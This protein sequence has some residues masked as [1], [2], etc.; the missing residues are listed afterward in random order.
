MRL[1]SLAR[2]VGWRG[3][4]LSLDIVPLFETI[5]DLHASESIMEKLYDI[6][7]Y[8]EHLETRDHAQTVMLGFSD[9]TKDGGYVSS[10]WSILEA[11]KRLTRSAHKRGYRLAFFDGRGG[12]PA[13][14]GGNA[15]LFYA[16]QGKE[17]ASEEIQLTIQGQTISSN[18]GSLDSARFNL[19]QLLSAGV[20]NEVFDIPGSSIS[21]PQSEIIE[22]LSQ[23]SLEYYLKLKKTPEFLP[24]LQRFGPMNYYG[25][26][27]IGSRP[28]TRGGKKI[29]DLK[30]LRAIP[31]VSTC[32]QMKQNIPGYYGLG[33]ALSKQIAAGKLEE[34]QELYRNCLFFRAL[35]D[36][37]TQSLSK[38]SFA[39]TSFIE[40]DKQFGELW[41]NIRDEFQRCVKCILQITGQKK[42]MDEHPVTQKSIAIREEIMLPLA[43]IQQY[44]LSRLRESEDSSELEIYEKMVIR[45]MYGIVNASRNS[46]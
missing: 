36:N 4:P 16:S 9:G 11:K 31:F 26:T 44:A 22:Q 42:L 37:S 45:S 7:E 27:N 41:K 25:K 34:L 19:E 24:Y 35:L 1:F 28:T 43:V 32:S 2:L 46:A 5:D 29:N 12:P 3:E 6:P 8:R 40:A 15:H 38:S 21:S 17:I 20:G 13:R 39:V 23:D 18:Y 30:S 14:G 33:Y 10:N